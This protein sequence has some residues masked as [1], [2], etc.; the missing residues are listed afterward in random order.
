MLSQQILPRVLRMAASIY[1]LAGFNQGA[2]LRDWTQSRWKAQWIASPDAP[3]RDAGVFH[4]RKTIN[5]PN[6]PASFVVY[7]SA[8]NRFILYVNGKQFGAGPASSDLFH[9]RYETFDLAP[10][11]HTGDNIIGATVWNFGIQ[12]QVA[13]MSDR[14]AFI[15]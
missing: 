10:L 13:Q 9:W 15:L 3:A 7:V 5:L 12:T 11:L 1:F 6:S 8:D 4:F 14:S 2:P